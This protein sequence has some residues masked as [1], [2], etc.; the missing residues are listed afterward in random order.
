[1]MEQNGSTS[2]GFR[3]SPLPGFLMQASASATEA[4]DIRTFYNM[5][6][7]NRAALRK[8]PGEAIYLFEP[9]PA[10]PR[11]VE[12][13]YDFGPLFHR[14]P[15]VPNLHILGTMNSADRNI[16]IVDVAVRRR[17]GFTVA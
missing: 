2:M 12:L 3:F 16:T 7:I 13:A 1:M 10:S 11:T 17:F 4:P 9:H 15:C 5:D 6:Q 8:I 14:R